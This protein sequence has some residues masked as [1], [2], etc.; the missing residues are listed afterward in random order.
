MA[1]HGRDPG[2]HAHEVAADPE[3]QERR[4]ALADVEESD[5]D[6]ELEP[7]RPPDVGRA[8]IPAPQGADVD[9]RDSRGSQYPH[10]MLPRT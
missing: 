5:G 7:E 1:D 9:S 2:E 4:G 6:S 8:G 3:A 10:G